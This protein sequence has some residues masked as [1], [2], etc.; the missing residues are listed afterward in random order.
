M[1]ALPVVLVCSTDAATLQICTW[2]FANQLLTRPQLRITEN[3]G[4]SDPK[5]ATK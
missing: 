5:E 4:P 3:H 2:Q 1:V